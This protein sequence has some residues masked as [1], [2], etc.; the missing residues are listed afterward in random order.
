[1]ETFKAKKLI[2][3][4]NMFG[5]EESKKTREERRS[6]IIKERIYN[7]PIFN[8]DQDF[9]EG[10][11]ELFETKIAKSLTKTEG[12][13]FTDGLHIVEMIPVAA[14][15]SKAIVGEDGKLLFQTFNGQDDLCYSLKGKGLK[16]EIIIRARR[17]E[18]RYKYKIQL[19]NLKAKL[20]DDEKVIF[21]DGETDEEIF[22]MADLTMLDASGEESRSI[23][24]SL[25]KNA[26]TMTCNSLWINDESRIL[27]ITI[28]PQIEVITKSHVLL[29]CV[30]QSNTPIAP[31][32]GKFLVGR[33]SQ[34]VKN[35]LHLFVYGQSIHRAASEQNGKYTLSFSFAKGLVPN[36]DAKRF[37]VLV[38]GA[39]YESG[40]KFDGDGRYNVEITDYVVAEEDV[41]II[42]E[43]DETSG[44][45][46][47]FFYAYDFSHGEEALRPSI[48]CEALDV[49]E[50]IETA[51]LDK[52]LTK[53]D[54]ISVDLHD[55]TYL[56]KHS[57]PSINERALKVNVDFVHTSLKR[58]NAEIKDAHM[59]GLRT[60]LHQYL[61][62]SSAANTLFGAR[63][64]LYID[65]DSRSHEL[66]ERWFYETETGFKNFV[67]KSS[68]FLDGDGMLKALVAGETH[69]VNYDVVSDDGLSLI[70]AASLLNYTEKAS[71]KVASRTFR[72]QLSGS[73]QVVVESS[74]GVIRMPH[75]THSP[76]LGTLLGESIPE[77]GW[78]TKPI[79]CFD[80][81]DLDTETWS[82]WIYENPSSVDAAETGASTSSAYFRTH[83][84]DLPLLKDETGYYVE[85]YSKK[86]LASYTDAGSHAIM[87]K[88][89]APAKVYLIEEVTYGY[90]QVGD[91]YQNEDI[92]SAVE[93]AKQI[94][95][96]LDELYSNR[97]EVGKSINM[98]DSQIALVNKESTRF[99]IQNKLNDLAAGS[100]PAKR[101][102]NYG[103]ETQAVARASSLASLH[104]QRISLLKQ[105]GS[106][107]GKIDEYEIMLETT[108]VEQE[109]LIDAQKDDVND[110]VIDEKG[111]AL[112]FDYH[113]KLI[114]I[115]DQYENKLEIAYDK[116]K[117]VSIKGEKEKIVFTYDE[118]TDLLGFV[119]DSKGRKLFFQHDIYKMIRRISEEQIE[120]AT[121]AVSL[122]FN[123]SANLTQINHHTGYVA[124]IEYLDSRV[125][126]IKQISYVD[127]LI[128][129]EIVPTQFS[130]GAV[131]VIFDNTIQYSANKA[132][133]TNALNAQS[134]IYAF[135][136]VGRVINEETD[137]IIAVNNFVEDMNVLHA[138]FDKHSQYSLALG[139]LSGLST[140]INLSLGTLPT[141]GT[142]IDKSDSVKGMYTFLIDV[143]ESSAV[144]R[145]I[146]LE[147]QVYKNAE[148]VS[149]TKFSLR[150][151][152]PRRQILALPVYVPNDGDS[153]Q[154]RITIKSNVALSTAGLTNPRLAKGE[155]ALNQFDGCER[156]AEQTSGAETAELLDFVG[157][158]ATRV[159]STDIREEVKTSH[160]EYDS[161]NHLVFA[162]DSQG[163]IE[164][165]YYNERGQ[166]IEKRSYREDAS[167]EVN[168]ST[169]KYDEFGGFIKGDHSQLIGN[170]ELV[171]QEEGEKEG[172]INFGYDFHTEEL[173]A[174][175]FIGQ[176]VSNR[177]RY[178]YANSL[179][180]GIS[181]NGFEVKYKLDYMG[182]K[183]ET[184]IADDADPIVSHVYDDHFVY[185]SNYPTIFGKMIRQTFK[186]G[187][188]NKY[189]YNDKGLLISSAFYLVASGDVTSTTEFVY[190]A[191]GRKTTKKVN[192]VVAETYAYHV[193]GE[194]AS[195]TFNGASESYTFD[196]KQRVTGISNTLFEHPVALEYDDRDKVKKVSADAI[197][198]AMDYD[199]L[200]RVSKASLA[201]NAG[202]VITDTLEYLTRKSGPTSLVKEHTKYIDGL[203][204][205]SFV[206]SYDKA[207]NIIRI[208]SDESNTRY[209]YDELNRLIREDNQTI[210]KTYL[211][212]YDAGGN[213]VSRRQYAYTLDDE[214][215]T[216]ES[217]NVFQYALS[218]HKDRLSATIIGGTVQDV[219]YDDMGRPLSYKGSTLV[220]NKRGTLTSYGSTSFAYNSDGIRTSKGS[221]AF[222]L[223][224]TRILEQITG[225]NSLKPIYLV[226]NMVGF[227]YNGVR[228]LFSKNIQ[229]DIVSLHDDDGTLVA[230]YV[231]DAWGNHEVFASNGQ[232]NTEASFVGNINPYRYRGYHYDVETKLYYLNSRYYDPEVGRFISPDIISILDETMMEANGLNLYMYC[233]NNPVMRVDPNGTAWWNWL[234]IGVQALAGIV[235]CL[236]PGGQAL[237]L[238]LLIGATI[239]AIGQL[240]APAIGQAI[241][242]ITSMANGWGAFSTGLSLLGAGLP[243]IIAG[244]GLMLIGGGTMA[245]G[246]NEVVAA[247]TGTNYIQKW[248]G[249]SEA[250]YGWTYF[251][252]NLASSVGQ[253]I[254]QRYMQLKTR[255]ATFNRNTGELKQYRYFDGNGNKLYD[256]D[257]NHSGNA[258]FP[259][260]H[261]W[262][263]N[264]TRITG[265]NGYIGLIIDLF[266]RL[267]G[268]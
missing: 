224:G 99:Q 261:A 49:G 239:G 98:V 235:A 26:L 42:V 200:N 245:F 36:V 203:R 253:L 206:Y 110:L 30:N 260:Y 57:G 86:E 208:A 257:F 52:Q 237:G 115:Q 143:L 114:M 14:F 33:F 132:I 46:P 255:S 193:N 70:S 144:T 25:E 51:T 228:Y 56:Y 126:V 85:I 254:G 185:D 236:I 231:Y 27:P 73:T 41:A 54:A 47:E 244:V 188:G 10:K 154:L 146:T 60:N 75:Y 64:A 243:G 106:V 219:A 74:P 232:E 256:I 31:V 77:P 63:K 95:K 140:V 20:I 129:S 50:A 267:F 18:Y 117:L 102:A 128:D 45:E 23:T 210:G 215:G 230:T 247:A 4:R 82:M 124:D 238:T 71:K 7:A 163:N 223:D 241:G 43:L 62:K 13:T 122:V 226:D 84:Y 8:D 227:W 175:T 155:W 242:G 148:E 178:T 201:K 149:K 159:V 150:Y 2:R 96:Y 105:L 264:L 248:T 191:Y 194:V 251:G 262:L 91:V 15:N 158:N 259:H 11:N 111:N 120:E 186:D 97:A 164:E 38:D 180:T 263:D 103:N 101:A 24:L 69:E 16:E 127:Y 37:K 6:S 135:D 214:P 40:L 119:T 197:S 142:R 250:A 167:S 44:A 225:A 67:D 182:R 212:R 81:A 88:A 207:G 118:Q 151:E 121:K 234:I 205:D 153:T 123:S 59:G 89:S 169:Y 79:D 48:R 268:V 138:S 213:I 177:T 157:R 202:E 181:H 58:N 161:D 137:D 139:T 94:N 184:T 17:A 92:K 220:W 265:H 76:L 165:T 172:I 131:P 174:K 1:M 83:Y 72:V 78:H 171:G 22:K 19:T 204:D 229:G 221:S 222:V 113:G 34:T 249:M 246:T 187:S 216:L 112:G 211:Y 196:A 3:E 65:G 80:A 5:R 87:H 147:A 160:Y 152:D 133:V 217:K 130:S 189:I 90:D 233:G 61:I 258:V 66:C 9:V 32:D 190:D 266:R 192:G 29:S 108:L 145:Q 35:Y 218:G 136:E 199:P 179:L 252:L 53:D 166:V 68:V 100:D 39:L 134:I 116:E 21:A 183:L 141:N 198:L 240:V 109:R 195:R 176:G 125:T 209:V 173:T 107:H 55:G 156:L 168:T 104:E 93:K 12:V 170:S 162:K 28:D